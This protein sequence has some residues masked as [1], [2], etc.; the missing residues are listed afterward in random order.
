MLCLLCRRLVQ[1]QPASAKNAALHDDV[2]PET[3]EDA[4]PAGRVESENLS[5]CKSNDCIIAF[6]C[7][8]SFF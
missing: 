2:R 5:R 7:F 3:V 4:R 6:K 1:L 8:N